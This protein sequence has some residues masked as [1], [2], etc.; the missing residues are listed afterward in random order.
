[1]RPGWPDL[2]LRRASL[3]TSVPS[4]RW[5]EAVAI[6]EG[7]IVAVGST[8]EVD[9]LI[10]PGTRVLDLPGRMVCPGFQD[11]HIHPNSGGLVK[12]RC[13]LHE[14]RGREAYEQAIRAYAES[15]RG[16]AWILGGGWALDDFPRGTPHRAVLDAIV[17]DRP[18]FLPNR[19]GH[20]AWVNTRALEMAGI[21]RDTPDP[22]DGRIE[23]DEDGAPL[24]VLHEGAMALV[25]R[26]IPEPTQ[27]ELE[28]ALITAQA[29]LHSLGITAWQ[30]A[31]VTG[32]TLQAY[33]G[34]DRSGKLTA[35]VVGALWWA[36]GRGEEQ[37]EDLLAMRARAPKGRFRATSVKIMQDGIPENFTAGMLEPYLDDQGRPSDRR[38]LSFV[39]PA[40][41]KRHVARLD[42]EGFQVHIHAIGDRAV[43]EALDAFEAAR[44][45]N[46]PNDHRHHIAHIQL[47]HPKD[48]PRFA[49]LDV[50]ANA[51]PYWA[52]LDGQ[53]R[54]L[55]IPFFGPERA[56]TQYPFASIRRAG[57]TLAFGSD[58]PVSTPDPLKE[59]QVAV[60]RVP[61]EEP[62]VEPFL[63][64]ERLDLAEALDAFTMGTAFVNHLDH[65][66]GSLE[67]GKLAD[68][69][70]LDRNPF[71]VDP[72]SIGEARVLLT[73]VDG[74]PVHVGTELAGAF[75]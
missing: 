16:A 9:G 38:G 49:G 53:M 32:S 58:W 39:G 8:G 70:V 50:V 27:A 63:P 13:E 42:R 37:V 41:L 4:S 31:H 69:V 25:E 71:D 19:D 10:G 22:P 36:R 33:L 21:T 23:R 75:G 40:A 1:M 12:N 68:L 61:Q 59:I 57:A 35:R 11:S 26:L 44:A 45:A 18:V 66:T 67:R 73:L 5:A 43:R 54:R 74:K 6:R 2:V 47:V 62:G 48:V 17:P 30:D 7:R 55:C 28:Q 14:V 52:C 51:Q 24:G 3:Y 46:G 29:Y 20:G 56:A 34:L 72:M 64:H 60:T 15:N 65:E